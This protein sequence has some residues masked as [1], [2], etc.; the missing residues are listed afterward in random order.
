MGQALYKTI[1]Q[2]TFDIAGDVQYSDEQ[3]VVSK[4][5]RKAV[6]TWLHQNGH[7]T[8]KRNGEVLPIL[9]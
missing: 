5:W 2:L 3:L 1:K 8:M 9:A 6:Q 7:I 4:S